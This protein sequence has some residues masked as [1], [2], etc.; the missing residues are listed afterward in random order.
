MKKYILIVSGIFL[1]NIITYG[2]EF[3]TSKHNPLVEKT[4]TEATTEEVIES[5]S[6]STEKSVT[7]TVVPVESVIKE[8]EEEIEKTNTGTGK[9]PR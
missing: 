7:T 4:N 5:V 8:E 1:S 9:N 2:Q 6:T 3:S